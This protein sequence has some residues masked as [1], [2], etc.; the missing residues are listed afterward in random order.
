MEEYPDKLDAEGKRLLNS[1]WANACSMSELID[2][3]LTFSPLG[4][5]PPLIPSML[6]RTAGVSGPGRLEPA[7]LEVEINRSTTVPARLSAFSGG[8]VWAETHK[9][10]SRGSSQHEDEES[11]TSAHSNGILEWST[12]VDRHRTKPQRGTSCDNVRG[13]IESGPDNSRALRIRPER[14]ESRQGPVD[15]GPGLPDECDSL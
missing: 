4:R 6:Q 13:P 11:S 12:H 3:L 8:D 15:D 1:I 9:H 14:V 5:Q 7:S 10:P 2:G